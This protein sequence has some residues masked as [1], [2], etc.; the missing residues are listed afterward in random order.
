MMYHYDDEEIKEMTHLT[1]DEYKEKLKTWFVV[2]EMM[3]NANM[4]RIYCLEEK[5]T[6]KRILAVVKNKKKETK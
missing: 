5:E 2:Q 3:P 4:L 1:P 6:K